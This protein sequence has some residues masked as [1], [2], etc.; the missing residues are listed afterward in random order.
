[1]CHWVG[2]CVPTSS[3]VKTGVEIERALALPPSQV[4]V[5]WSPPAKSAGGSRSDYNSLPVVVGRRRL[6]EGA[7]RALPKACQ[8]AW[9]FADEKFLN[10]K[11]ATSKRNAIQ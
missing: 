1:M 6:K 10:F 9:R 3:S 5:G 2:M 7:L 4:I 11:V 8:G